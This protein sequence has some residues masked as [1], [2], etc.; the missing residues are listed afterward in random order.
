M[1]ATVLLGA[2]MGGVT[3]SACYKSAQG[4]ASAV[5]RS[6]AAQHR[7]RA[8]RCNRDRLSNSQLVSIFIC[9]RCSSLS[10]MTLGGFTAAMENEETSNAKYQI[11]RHP[12]RDRCFCSGAFGYAECECRR[13]TQCA[14][15]KAPDDNIHKLASSRRICGGWRK[16]R[17]RGVPAQLVALRGRCNIGTCWSFVANLAEG[18]NIGTAWRDSK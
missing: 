14:N 2:S 8:K 12:C 5:D 15:E 3:K 11:S 7:E 13:A 1:P 18:T 16:R 9:R 4:F 10:L 6:S 17:Y